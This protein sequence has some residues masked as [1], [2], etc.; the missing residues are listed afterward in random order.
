LGSSTTQKRVADPSGSIFSY[1]W[2]GTG[3][4][5]NCPRCN[6]PAKII[7]DASEGGV[8]QNSA[9]LTCTVC[10][11]R[12]KTPPK[13]KGEALRCW[14]CGTP[15]IDQPSYSGF[16]GSFT[17]NTKICPFCTCLRQGRDPYFGLP[18]LL[19]ARIGR[20]E[21]WAINREHLVH[22]RTFI[23][24][25]L[26]ERNPAVGLSLTAMARLPAWAKRASARSSVLR[27]LDKMHSVANDHKL[28]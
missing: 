9:V 23:G 18:F 22:M 4:W 20:H 10:A 5:T 7:V 8:F 16:P 6:G 11:Y 17:T 3:I 19:K 12:E 28:P 25:T 13:I 27:A 24:G 15:V 26:R 1:L 21:L 2:D 14:G